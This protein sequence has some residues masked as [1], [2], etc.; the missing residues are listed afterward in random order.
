MV[1]TLKTQAESTGAISLVDPGF[2]TKQLIKQ[3]TDD[4]LVKLGS[5]S[6]A[7]KLLQ[8]DYS[9]LSA[10]LNRTQLELESVSD[11]VCVY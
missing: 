6:N 11:L 10:E 5:L 4:A 1:L 9:S 2:E 7:N 8:L 3:C